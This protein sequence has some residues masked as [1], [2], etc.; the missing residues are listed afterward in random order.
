MAIKQ[1]GSVV[2]TFGGSFTS[3]YSSGPVYI[4]V[5]NNLEFQIVVN[6][7]GTSVSEVGFVVKAPNG[8]TIYQRNKGT[9]FSAGMIF[10]IVCLAGGC[11]ATNYFTLTANMTDSYGDGWNSNILGIRQNGTIVGY[12]G[13]QFISGFS[14]GPLEIYVLGDLIT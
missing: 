10:K 14:N 1:N 11:P 6:N 8:T 4:S 7:F 2:G 5:K 3:G 9:I 12:F 13:N